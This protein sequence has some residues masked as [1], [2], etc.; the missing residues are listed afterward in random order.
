[1]SELTTEELLQNQ[2]YV[3]VL[4]RRGGQENLSGDDIRGFFR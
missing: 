2:D 1:M 3:D 4:I